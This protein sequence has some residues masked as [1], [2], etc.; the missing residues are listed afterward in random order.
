MSL[1]PLPERLLDLVE[2]IY[3]SH[4]HGQNDLVG[5][6]SFQGV[7]ATPHRSIHA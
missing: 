3:R 5:V 7:L 2:G 1:L 6:V 4:P